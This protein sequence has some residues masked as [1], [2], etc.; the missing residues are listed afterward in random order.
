M[1]LYIEI[2]YLSEAGRKD[3]LARPHSLFGMWVSLSRRGE[4]VRQTHF[5][6]A[7]THLVSIGAR[8]HAPRRSSGGKSRR[9]APNSLNP[10]GYGCL[11]QLCLS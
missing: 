9:W 7:P 3:T 8:T 2:L 5:F 6:S 10:I 4:L 11:S 1:C